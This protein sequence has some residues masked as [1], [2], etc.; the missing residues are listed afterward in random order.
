MI[1]DGKVLIVINIAKGMKH[2]YCQKKYGFSS[3]GCP[4]RV[5]T[6]CKEMT[7]EQ[8]K[9]RYESR[10]SDGEYNLLAELLADRNNI[11]FIFVKF[12]GRDKSAIFERSDYGHRC[13]LT[14]YEQGDI[15]PPLTEVGASCSIQLTL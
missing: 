1:P 15:L 5:G 11:P 9:I 4:I 7:A 3:I 12:K 2:I 13:I 14:S 8:I 6:T 10:L